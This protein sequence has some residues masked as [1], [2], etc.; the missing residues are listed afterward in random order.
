MTLSARCTTSSNSRTKWWTSLWL[1]RGDACEPERKRGVGCV[2]HYTDR[3]K[4]LHF[5]K[6]ASKR[7]ACHAHVSTSTVITIVQCV[8][9][10]F[11]AVAIPAQ[12]CAKG[13]S[14]PSKTWPTSYAKSAFRTLCHAR[15]FACPCA[16]Q[17]R[18][19]F[20]VTAGFKCH[21]PNVSAASRAA[22]T[23]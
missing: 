23:K 13:A 1:T 7:V 3:R 19:T 14:A 12:H 22:N 5:K 4:S 20:T 18:T 11:T 10:M 2:W 8:L 6:S 16:A 17:S 9:I 15:Q 21:W